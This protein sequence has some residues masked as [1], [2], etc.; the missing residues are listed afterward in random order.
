MEKKLTE[1]EN[2]NV[3]FAGQTMLEKLD[4]GVQYFANPLRNEDED[5]LATLQALNATLDQFK[6][7]RRR[8]QNAKKNMINRNKNKL[9]QIRRL[10][11]EIDDLD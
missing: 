5:N 2:V 9:E 4:E 6:A 1:M 7:E 11:Q 3:D 8:L 10:R